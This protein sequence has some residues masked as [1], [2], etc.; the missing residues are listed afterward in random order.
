MH[1][2][3]ENEI[4]ELLNIR[5]SEAIRRQITG[6]VKDSVVYNRVSKLLA[7][8]GVYRTHMQVISKLKALRKQYTKYHQQKI[9]FGGDRV[10]WPFYEQ[11]HLA[12]GSS[13]PMLNTMKRPRSPTP[14][15]PPA[16]P[17]PPPAIS[18]KHQEVVVSLWDEVDD[19]D[20][21]KHLGPVDV[22][23]EEE[24]Y[25]P[26]EPFHPIRTT[27]TVPEKKTRKT[28]VMEQVSTL[29]SATVS[30]LK[31][32]DASMQAQEDARLQRLMEHEKEMQNSLM[33]QLVA[34]HERIS[35]ENHERHLELVDRILS[36]LPSPSSSSG[37]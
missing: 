24:Q 18:G 16:P 17:P 10:D 36:S 9:R 19:R 29:V 22:D 5:G 23:D 25:S 15:P 28:T 31:E 7:E 1:N 34:M 20:I 32:M 11:C 33:N 3:Q 37:P 13:P 4:K 21:N 35:Q 14:P 27:Y 6:T 30:Q 8:R 12:F 26:P 2:W